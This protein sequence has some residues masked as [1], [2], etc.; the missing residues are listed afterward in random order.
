MKF[1]TTTDLKNTNLPVLAQVLEDG[2]VLVQVHSETTEEASALA[3]FIADALQ[4]RQK[5]A[6]EDEY[7]RER[8]QDR[9]RQSQEKR[10]KKE[11]LRK[12]PTPLVRVP[13]PTLLRILDSLIRHGSWC[14]SSGW[15]WTT[16]AKTEDWLISLVRRG[17]VS[18]SVQGTANGQDF[19]VY[20]P[21][22]EV[23]VEYYKKW[24]HIIK[25]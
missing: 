17:V 16:T 5:S 23:S 14:R 13:T 10:A 19:Y 20:K 4:Q 15:V 9:Y 21:I 2:A 12:T 3:T 22:P 6:E 8:N 25:D 24:K 18:Q 11:A 7:W 1:T